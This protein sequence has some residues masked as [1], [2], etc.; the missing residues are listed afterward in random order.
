MRMR[1]TG[2]ALAIAVSWP[3][4]AMATGHGPVFG[5]ATPT[6]GRDGWSLDLA[7][8]VRRNQTDDDDQML[9]GMIGYGVTEDLQIS[10]SLPVPLGGNAQM[11]MGRMMA[12]MSGNR[13]VETIVGWRFHRRAIGER[14]RFESTAYVG[15]TVPL[16][17]QRAGMRTAPSVSA[18]LASGYAS[19]AHYFWIGGSYLRSFEEGGERL[20]DVKSLSVVYGFRPEALRLDYPKPDLRFFVESVAERTEAARHGNVPL[21]NTGGDLVLAGPTFLLL[22]KAYGL[23][24]GVMLP[25]HQRL[26]GSQPKERFRFGLNASYFFW[27]R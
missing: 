25:L 6:L 15:A 21:A 8:M 10:A 23:S 1:L 24:G 11:P 18:S 9:R 13:D 7:W 20:G 17:H 26:N 12:M 2:V 14:A 5:A 19:R 3:G 22:Y 16:E 27:L 4:A